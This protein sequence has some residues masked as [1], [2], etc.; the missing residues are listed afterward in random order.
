MIP[1][2]IEEKSQR[3]GKPLTKETNI[4]SGCGLD[5]IPPNLMAGRSRMIPIFPLRSYCPLLRTGLPLNCTDG[6]SFRRWNETG[7]QNRRLQHVF[8]L[9]RRP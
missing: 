4:V 8:V 9:E 2:K 6:A 5:R 3:H 7:N 1:C